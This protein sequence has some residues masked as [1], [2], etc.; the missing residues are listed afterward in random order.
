MHTRWGRTISIGDYSPEQASQFRQLQTYF[1]DAFA[2][3]ILI[4]INIHKF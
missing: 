4:L 2:L 1:L 3:V